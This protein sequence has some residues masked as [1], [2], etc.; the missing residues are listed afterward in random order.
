[1]I[2]G[3]HRGQEEEETET[4]RN[5]LKKEEGRERTE[6]GRRVRNG[7]GEEGR[8]KEEERMRNRDRGGKGVR[9]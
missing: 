6:R 4:V 5:R 8:R 7:P 1:M 3:A 2:E 9:E